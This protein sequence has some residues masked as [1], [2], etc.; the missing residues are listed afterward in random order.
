MFLH[1]SMLIYVDYASYCHV[2][3][4]HISMLIYVDYASYCHVM[5]L[6]ISMLIYVDYASYCKIYC[7]DIHAQV[8]INCN[9]LVDVMILGKKNLHFT[10]TT[11]KII[12]S[13]KKTSYMN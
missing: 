4:L 2:M 10:H 6:H 8:V 1:I 3:F 9:L 13:H 11:K 12:I 5:F 7:L